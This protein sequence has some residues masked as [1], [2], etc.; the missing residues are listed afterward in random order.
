[1]KRRNFLALAGLGA[2][3]VIGGASAIALQNQNAATHTNDALAEQERI[4][5]SIPGLITQLDLTAN[6]GAF[7][8]TIDDASESEVLQSYL[9]RAVTNALSFTF[10]VNSSKRSWVEQAERLHPLIKSGQ[11][12]LANHSHRHLDLTT[13]SDLKVRNEIAACHSFLLDNF[14]VDA[15]PFWRPPFRKIDQRVAKIAADLGYLTP[16]LWSKN[17]LNAS[18]STTAKQ[19]TSRFDSEVT[20]GAILLDHMHGLQTKTAFDEAV[21]TL[22]TKGLKTVTLRDALGA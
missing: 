20:A 15:R 16:T 3:S 2:A 13:L 11:I 1:M 19:A 7:A 18:S 10:F 4:E 21:L 22:Q 17:L 5:R 9:E 12:Q 8:W 6:P 14:G